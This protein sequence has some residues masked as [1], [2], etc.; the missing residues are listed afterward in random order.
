MKDKVIS[1]KEKIELIIDRCRTF[2]GGNGLIIPHSLAKIIREKYGITEG[3]IETIPL[4]ANV[5]KPI[6]LWGKD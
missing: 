2:N 5:S 3:Y 1:E 6:N 4:V